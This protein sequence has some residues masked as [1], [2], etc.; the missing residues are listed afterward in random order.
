[1]SVEDLEPEFDN[2]QEY[3]RGLRMHNY[4]LQGEISDKFFKDYLIASGKAN[5]RLLKRYSVAED[6]T[7]QPKRLKASACTPEH[8]MM[9]GR[10]KAGLS[11]CIRHPNGDCAKLPNEINK[12]WEPKLRYPEFWEK[13]DEERE[14]LE[15][16][17]M[18]ICESQAFRA[19]RFAKLSSAFGKGLNVP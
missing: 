4:R 17:E 5:N 15:R 16:H 13:R 11:A 14:R 6:Q 3:Q 18:G 7:P 10:I 9:Q 1:M 8:G 2:T 19:R 12:D